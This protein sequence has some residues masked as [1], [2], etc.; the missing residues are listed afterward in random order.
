M[1]YSAL[2]KSL[3]RRL[4]KGTAAE[5]PAK[6]TDVDEAEFKQELDRQL[7]KVAGFQEQKVRFDLIAQ[8]DRADHRVQREDPGLRPAREQDVQAESARR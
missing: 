5:G 4:K 8:A 7:V 6:W 1:D 3:N 2:K